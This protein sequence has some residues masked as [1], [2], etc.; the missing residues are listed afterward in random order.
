MTFRESSQ[1]WLRMA[2]ER[3]RAQ[4]WW[5]IR[6]PRPAGVTRCKGEIMPNGAIGVYSTR[7]QPKEKPKPVRTRLARCSKGHVL[8]QVFIAA[9]EEWA[10][11]C[12]VCGECPKD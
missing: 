12:L 8:G 7:E 1:S 5:S 9:T 11:D 6:S 4:L 2:E 10:G 3:Q